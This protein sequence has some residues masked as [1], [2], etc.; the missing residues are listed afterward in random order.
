MKLLYAAAFAA[1]FYG[2]VLFIFNTEDDTKRKEGKVWMIWSVIA[3]FVMITIWGIVG[4]LTNT[5][6]GG[7][8]PSLIPQLP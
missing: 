2:I 7:V 1:F 4:I 6:F 3:L 5:F 8:T